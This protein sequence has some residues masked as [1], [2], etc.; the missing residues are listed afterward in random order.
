MDPTL[1]NKVNYGDSY[2]QEVARRLQL[3]RKVAMENNLE[4]KRV[5]REQHDQKVKKVEF[6]RGQL[7]WL[8]RPDLPSTNVKLTCCWEGPYVVVE[9]T[10]ANVLITHVKNGKTRFVHKDRVKLYRGRE[11]EAEEAAMADEAI[12]AEQ[13]EKAQEEDVAEVPSPLPYCMPHLDLDTEVIVVS[14]P[15]LPPPQPIRIKVDDHAITSDETPVAVKA[16]P[17]SPVAQEVSQSLEFEN[18]SEWPRLEQQVATGNTLLR[19]I[20]KFPVPTPVD[21]AAS[22]FS[23]ARTRG[24]RRDLGLPPVDGR[25]LSEY[26]PVR[27]PASK[28]SRVNDS[29]EEA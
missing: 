8:Y 6:C 7:V 21:L 13:V 12:E 2:A 19:N 14:D 4:Y 24:E 16:E 20:R 28:R 1:M 5:Y 22:L 3:V 27:R 17:A 11:E 18:E 29:M 9:V 26:P 25:V 23:R 15:D 10:E